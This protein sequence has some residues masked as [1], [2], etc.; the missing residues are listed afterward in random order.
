[1][2]S[3]QR[4][5]KYCAAGIAVLLAI[6][7][8]SF[9]VNVVYGVV[10]LTSGS[11]NHSNKN[12]FRTVDFDQSYTGVTGLNIDNSTGSLSIKTGDAFRV[13]GIDVIEG[14]RAEVDRNGMLTVRDDEA[15]FQVLGVNLNGFNN[16]GSK[17]TI[18]LPADFI[19]E[20]AIIETGAG[21]VDL[22]DFSTKYLCISAGAGSIKG[23]NLKADE[24]EV[25]GGV[26]SL[27]LSDVEFKNTSFECGVGNVYVSGVL[28]EE[29]SFDCG[30]GK[31]ELELTGDVRDYDMDIE[32]GMG[33][34]R[35]N[36][37]RI[38]ELEYTNSIAEHSIEV[39]GGIGSVSINFK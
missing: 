31:V 6:G 36:G 4:V 22:E 13:E 1:M 11:G 15:G 3:T 26:G 32:A 7:I 30:V 24:V 37:K 20:R 39:D 21:T 23:R 35:V 27:R 29:N 10:T 8:I 12:G 19:A 34:V 38:E 16:S 18:Y 17:V 5:I 28:L 9:F 25:N 33:S 14:F 2:S